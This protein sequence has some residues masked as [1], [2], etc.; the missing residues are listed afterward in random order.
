MYFAPLSSLGF[1]DCFLSSLE[2]LDFVLDILIMFFQFRF[3]LINSYLTLNGMERESNQ[4]V[5][6]L[7]S[8]A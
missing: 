6:A 5:S 3:N 1:F 2:T 7:L 8:H 4:D